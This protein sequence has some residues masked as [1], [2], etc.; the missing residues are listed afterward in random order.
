MLIYSKTKTEFMN[1]MDDDVLVKELEDTIREKMHCKTSL[2]EIRSWENSLEEMYMVLNSSDIPNTCG[3][4]IEYNVPLTSKRVDFIVS[5]IDEN[6]TE[7]AQIIELKQWDH[8]E[9]VSGQDAIVRTYVG[10]GNREISHPSYQAWS[11]AQL[12]SD[13]N[14]SVQD[15]GIVLHPCAFAHNY[16]ID[17]T[18]VL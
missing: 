9:E 15:G 8:A 13:Y 3:I 6:D 12:I 2:G 16:C 17:D 18:A 7:H 14:T 5:G 10:G 11:Y 4:A 1:D